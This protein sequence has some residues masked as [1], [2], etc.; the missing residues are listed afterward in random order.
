MSVEYVVL[1]SRRHSER[2]YRGP[3]KRAVDR[4]RTGL[5]VD[6][7]DAPGA[8][9]LRREPSVEAVAPSMPMKLIRPV[10]R[11]GEA[12]PGLANDWGISAIAADRSPFDGRGAVVAVLD[13]GI[14]RNHPAFSGVELVEKDF[15]GVGNGDQDGHGTHCA[16]TLFGRDVGGQRIG[17]AR[18]VRKA[19]I[20]KVIGRNGGSS[21]H[22]AAAIHW[23]VDEGAHVVSMSIGIDFPGY[24]AWLVENGT[25]IEVATSVALEAYRQNIRL[26][27]RLA[28]LVTALTAFRQPC[29]LVAATGNESGRDRVPPYE[30]AAGPPASSDDFIAVG[31]LKP[32]PMGFAA[33]DFSNTG[34]VLSAPG[35]GIVSADAGRHLIAMDGT[36]MATPHVAGVAALWVQKLAA[37]QELGVGLLRAKVVSSAIR[38]SLD[39]DA[40]QHAV[41]GGIV[42]APG[43]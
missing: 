20:A 18:G 1:R 31:A 6:L 22:S 33:A 34:G 37:A 16:G 23:A 28:S 19:L 38:T 5:E 32:G 27:D 11:A 42:Q 12:R 21:A 10:V 3:A 2:V 36:S 4:W 43:A 35:V 8:A 15:T 25:R 24:L 26:F 9:R 17:V 29:L 14:D 41:G 7:V 40:P 39:P 13:T 30:I